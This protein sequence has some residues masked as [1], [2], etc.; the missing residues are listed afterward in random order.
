MEIRTHSE[1]HKIEG[2][3]LS[4]YETIG[5]VLTQL[6]TFTAREMRGK[7]DEKER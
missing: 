7:S 2:A 4:M 5:V 6:Q 3:S 1:G